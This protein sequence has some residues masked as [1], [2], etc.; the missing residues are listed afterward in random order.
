[1]AKLPTS[2]ASIFATGRSDET[3]RGIKLFLPGRDHL[4]FFRRFITDFIGLYKFNNLMIEVNAGMRLER[5]PNSM[6]VSSTLLVTW[7]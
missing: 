7:T 4:A 5:H 1:M 6:P 2:T 3:F